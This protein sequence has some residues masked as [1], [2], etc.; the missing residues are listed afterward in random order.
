MR[1]AGGA[2]AAFGAIVVLGA[3]NGGFFADSWG[4][5]ALPLLLLT[6]G[7]LFATETV[8][9]SRAEVLWLGSLALLTAW[10]ALSALWAPDAGAPVVEATRA[11][12]YLAAIASVVVL[13]TRAALP[14]AVLAACFVLSA[15]ALGDAAAG[16]GGARLEGPI[17]YTNGLGLVA[18]TGAILAIGLAPRHRALVATLAVFLPTLVLTYSR[19]SWVALASGL[20][21]LGAIAARSRPRLLVAGGAAAVV[22]VIAALLVA[23]HGAASSG[24]SGRLAS[25]SGNGR[26]DYWR[27]A[28]DETRAHPVF[29]GGG[30]TW[31]RWW[32]ANRP[33]ANGALDAHSL[34][35]ETLAEL[36]PIGL[37]LLVAWLS[38]PFFSLRRFLRHDWA[39]PCLAAYV[40]L[41]VHAALDWDWELPAVALSGLLC[42][43][44]LVGDT[45]RFRVPRWPAL[46]AAAA[47]AVVMF[48][49]QVGNSA[50]RSAQQALDA[51]D[52]GSAGARAH[53]A[54]SWQPW[55]S[56]PR[57]LLGQAQL[58]AGD[59]TTAA[60]TLARVTRDD[61][62]NADAWYQL[63]LASTGARRNLALKRAIFLDPHGPA[64]SLR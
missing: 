29:G 18:A 2:C 52:A 36:G 1:R 10:T 55:T 9:L 17:G 37:A 47:L 19:G 20:A 28:L 49:L 54:I 31:S 12:L 22:L 27:V 58:A 15:W 44:A 35:L 23:R 48:V 59:V 50:A 14:W 57:L 38:L 16:R 24:G 34:Y 21:V 42:A 4:W 43:T 53:R 64:A 41:L 33:N 5:V 60:R 7:V 25:L 56:D 61:P 51:G 13:G 63:A 26:G 3:Q 32:L 62:G 46:A 30:G 40:A 6:G 45:P 11:L 8:A 39:A